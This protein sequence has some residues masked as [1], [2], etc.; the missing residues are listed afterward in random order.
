MKTLSVREIRTALT[1]LEEVLAK[2][3]ELVVTRHG[4]PIARV[5]PVA[6]REAMP[7][8]KDFRSK[9]SRLKVGSERYVRAD[10]DDR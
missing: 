3:G 4:Q 10:R 9:M 6:R 8:H 1:R 7:S 5:L 2:E